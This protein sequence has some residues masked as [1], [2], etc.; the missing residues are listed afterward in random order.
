MQVN[1]KLKPCPFCG[2][3]AKTYDYEG[4]RDI[5]DPDTL[6]Y[7]DTEYFTRWGCGCEVCG[8]MVPEKRSE[9]EAI[10]AWNTRTERTCKQVFIECN[11]GLMPPFTAHCSECGAGWGY[12]PDYCPG[13]GAKVIL[14]AD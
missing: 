5:Y 11:D 12:T 14:N 10:E 6:G 7:V 4:K 2:G 8:A 13:C 9:E 1:D 3:K